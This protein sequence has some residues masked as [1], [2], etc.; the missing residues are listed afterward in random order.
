MSLTKKVDVGKEESDRRDA[1]KEQDGKYV[2]LRDRHFKGILVGR[3]EKNERIDE[4]IL[5]PFVGNPINLCDYDL[6]VME[7]FCEDPNIFGDLKR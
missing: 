1:I 2:L 7:V 4:Y 5:H 3:I 6:E